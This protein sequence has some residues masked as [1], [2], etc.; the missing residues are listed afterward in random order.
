M[1][2]D[3]VVGGMESTRGRIPAL[4]FGYGEWD[5][6]FTEIHHSNTKIFGLHASSLYR[7]EV[8]NYFVCA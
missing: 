6:L 7:I 4:V 5:C 2:G 1:S 3:K 8:Q